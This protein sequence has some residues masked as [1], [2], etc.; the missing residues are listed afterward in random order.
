MRP[1]LFTLG[2]WSPLALPIIAVALGAVL[3]LWTWLDARHRG[4]RGRALDYAAGAG[5]AILAALALYFLVNRFGPVYIRSWG[6]MLLVAMVAALL[7]MA[8][9]GR[10]CGIQPA[11]L[12]D[13]GLVVLVVAI[14]G[15]RLMYVA[16]DWSQ[17]S[18]AP[19]SIFKVWEGGLSFHGGLIGGI[20][21]GYGLARLRRVKFS[22]LADLAAPALALGYAFARIG[23]FLNGCCYGGAC[24][25]FWGVR[26]APGSEAAAFSLGLPPGAVAHGWGNPLYPTQLM[27]CALSLIVFGI[28]VL[29]RP[30][31]KRPG[32]L[33]VA[34]IGLYAVER[35]VVEFWRAGA[36]GRPFPGIP[37]LTWAQMASV[38][39]L[40]VAAIILA[41]T[42]PR[43]EVAQASQ[44]ASPNAAQGKDAGLEACATQGKATRKK[45]DQRK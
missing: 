33:F 45:K 32:H 22:V 31:F 17:F 20:A 25:T 24:S 2:P 29:S 11:F 10:R 39:M 5:G 34:Y 40:L 26:F 36:S 41:A 28:L 14:I 23:C 35:F 18:A 16:L 12:V 21:A 4:V 44:P 6:F 27:D 15:A 30:L 1:I 3:S 38:G 42:W 19:L 7:W 13:L 43:R 8:H 37:F 9:S